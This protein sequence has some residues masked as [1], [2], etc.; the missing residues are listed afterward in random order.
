MSG[1]PIFVVGSMR[2]GSTMLRLILDSHPHIAVGPET[3][4]MGALL[5][6]KDIPAWRF[7]K[8]WYE[9]LNWT[10]QEVDERLRDFYTGMFHRYATEQGKQRWGEKTPF[11]TGHMAEM[12][13]VFPD[14]VFV[15]IV[16]HPGAVAASLRKNFHYTIPNAVSYWM[17]TNLDLVRAGADLG[18]RFLACRYEDLVV[19]SEPV[20]RELMTF[21]DEP[22]SP[23]LLEHH[24]VQRQKGAPRSVDGSTITRDPIDPKRVGSWAR[25]ATADDYAALDSA[26]E[27]S[28]FFG[29]DPVDPASRQ[30]LA[31]S[32][33]PLR[34]TVTG[35]D[36][37]VRRREWGG[38]I[39]FDVRPPT[40]VIDASPEELADRL[41]RV[42]RALVRVRSRKS[43]RMSD[44]FRK[45]QH[46]RSLGD[47][48]EAWSLLRGSQ[49][50]GRN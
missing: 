1:G 26:A 29:Y 25:G 9:R 16:R 18:Q 8:G 15:G 33:S 3:G 45:V 39:D 42:E 27:L 4:F 50:A 10:E 40:L 34:C 41:S 5:S 14:A 37:A 44:A 35:E 48:R 21:L 20:L 38:R 24:H 28:G 23:N 7:G 30:S 2:S 49:Q 6:T 31:S 36:L 47:V 12:A 11:H 19:E 13:R 43:V 32:D 22:W 17:A 46:G